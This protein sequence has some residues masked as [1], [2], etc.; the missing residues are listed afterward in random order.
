MLRVA[1]RR[2]LVT[3]SSE[4]ALR[5]SVPLW[6]GLT[7]ASFG[8][9][10]GLALSDAI[11]SAS[12]MILLIVPAA[13]FFQT[14]R[15]ANRAANNR[16]PCS[17]KGEAQQR[18]IKRIMVFSSA[19]LVAIALQVSLL[20]D[21]D[22]STAARVAL[23]LLP[24]FAIIGV[25]WAIGRLI[26]EEQDEFLRMLIVRQALIATGFALAAATLWGFLE[27]TGVVIHLDA[28]W[29]AV[30]WFFG[31]FVGA[32]ANRISYGTWGAL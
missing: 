10:M 21:G 2:V 12:A 6:A 29:W 25:F 28:Y 13:L 3:E 15:A 18:Y 23:A 31:Q 8:A 30:A 17:A 9:V 5:S 14:M 20:S 1:Q 19:Y 22:P 16:G 24:A 32:V 4:N 27:S 26:V 11:N 7:F